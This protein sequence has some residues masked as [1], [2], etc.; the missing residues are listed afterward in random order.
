MSDWYYKNRDR[1]LKERMEQYHKDKEFREKKKESTLALYY[2]KKS[3]CEAMA[4]G[5]NMFGLKPKKK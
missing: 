3:M 2:K 5:G 4:S 1:I